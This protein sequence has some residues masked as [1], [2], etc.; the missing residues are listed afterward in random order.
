MSFRKIFT[1]FFEM[2][3]HPHFHLLNPLKH[4]CN[5]CDRRTLFV[6]DFAADRYIR[7]CIYCRS[8][9]KYRAIAKAIELTLARPLQQLMEEDTRL[10]ELS[11]TSSI[12]RKYIGSGNYT[13]S[14]YFFDKPF[15]MPLRPG[16]YNQDCQN[17]SF[18]DSSYDLVVSSETMEHVRMPFAGFK[19]I[20]RVLKP[21]GYYFFTI[22]YRDDRLTTSRVDISGNEDVHILPKLYHQDPYR[23]EG[24]LVYTDFGRDLPELL[25]KIGFRTHLLSISDTIL[26]IQ[27][28]MQPM[29][30]F[31]A[32]AV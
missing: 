30:V 13:C 19:E 18:P 29:K 28:D 7:K 4:N 11:T 12:H 20:R 32:K 16:V 24:A 5:I 3:S 15:G 23:N 14:G 25:E 22:P 21:G 27:D 26:D 17:L 10:Y 31:V 1:K 6:C 2:L 8:T 9:P